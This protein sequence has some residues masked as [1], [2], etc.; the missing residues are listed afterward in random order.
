MFLLKCLFFFFLLNNVYSD[1]NE[2]IYIK[3]LIG[4]GDY[5]IVN[6]QSNTGLQSIKLNLAIHDKEICGTNLYDNKENI[7]TE[8]FVKSKL[9]IEQKIMGGKKVKIAF[10]PWSVQI[11]Y[12]NKFIC[13]GTLVARNYIMSA[14]HCIVEN[15]HSSKVNKN[16]IQKLEV[17]INYPGDETSNFIDKTL[18]G[19]HLPNLRRRI[20]SILLPSFSDSGN[21]QCQ[22]ENDFAILELDEYIPEGYG[23][24]CL[25][26]FYPPMYT[27]YSSNFYIVGY[28][29]NPYREERMMFNQNSFF[30][31][32]IEINNPFEY[33]ENKIQKLEVGVLITYPACRIKSS[34]PASKGYICVYDKVD[35]G[36]CDG[37]SGSGLFIKHKD[38]ESYQQEQTI[39][40]GIVSKAASCLVGKDWVATNYQLYTDVFQHNNMY[41]K[42]F[43]NE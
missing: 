39:L 18:E 38:I 32:N 6:D 14:A 8:N 21:I 16:D 43:K 20:R 4:N 41:K 25:P 12:L 1:F 15:C 28:G 2:A 9:H 19:F 22:G 7:K 17:L 30:Q 5:F 31:N 37:D 26:I 34:I 36:I 33:N 27:I 23:Y 42:F 13:G 40:V 35:E 11:Y 10:E 29:R 3:N 24:A